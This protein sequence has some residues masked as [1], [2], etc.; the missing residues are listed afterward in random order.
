MN[1]AYPF[2]R[3]ATDS[4]PGHSELM[5]RHTELRY[6]VGAFMRLMLISKRLL[7]LFER[8]CWFK[9]LVHTCCQWGS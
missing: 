7:P 5:D 2:T 8:V 4:T 6:L 3:H 9:H 1:L